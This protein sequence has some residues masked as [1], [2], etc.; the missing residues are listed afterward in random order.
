MNTQSSDK[1]KVKLLLSNPKKVHTLLKP[2]QKNH[3]KSKLRVI[4]AYKAKLLLSRHII[5]EN[6]TTLICL[7]V[8][9]LFL[10][11]VIPSL[12]TCHLKLFK[13]F[14]ISPQANFLSKNDNHFQI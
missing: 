8:N 9:Y 14:Y 10:E 1:T 13:L 2:K 4:S 11:K 5:Y 3:V 12:S 7:L 6:A